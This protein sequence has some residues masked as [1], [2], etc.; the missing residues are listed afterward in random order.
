MKKTITLL[1]ATAGLAVAASDPLDITWDADNKASLQSSLDAI[2]VVFT[3][4]LSQLTATGLYEPIK[5]PIFQWDGTDEYGSVNGGVEHY[6]L[7]DPGYSYSNG[8]EGFYNSSGSGYKSIIGFTEAIVGY[9]YGTNQKSKFYLTL[10]DAQ[11]VETNY[12]PVEGGKTRAQ[13]AITNLTKHTGIGEI[14]VYDSVLS[15]DEITS[16]MKGMAAAPAVPE[17][18]TATLSLLALAGLA[19]RRRRR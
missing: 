11:G 4:D 8:I 10:I 9:T 19:A 1:L 2:S 17:P 18:T 7:D 5:T 15:A 16:A 13:L 3:F 6:Y 12:E 14:E